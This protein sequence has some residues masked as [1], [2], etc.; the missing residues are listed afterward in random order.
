MVHTFEFL[1]ETEADHVFVCSACGLKVG[2]NKPEIGAPNAILIDGVW[3][4]PIDVEDYVSRCIG[5]E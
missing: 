3:H 5:A 2:F 4:P 1:E